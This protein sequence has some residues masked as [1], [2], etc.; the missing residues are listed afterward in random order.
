MLIK[1]DHLT[2]IRWGQ[3]DKLRVSLLYTNKK[4]LIWTSATVKL[5][6]FIFW[7][8]KTPMKWKCFYWQQ[9]LAKFPILINNHN[10]TLI[11]SKIMFKATKFSLWYF[12]I[13]STVAKG[14]KL[15]ILLENFPRSTWEFGKYSKLETFSQS[16]KTPLVTNLCS[17][18]QMLIQYLFFL[19]VL[20]E[21]CSTW[22]HT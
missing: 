2:I 4:I 9:T 10:F 16:T 7:M 21:H 18:R 6:M 20:P 19:I 1:N 22:K 5:Q 14:R 17:S 11:R 15:E 8:F 3:S 12:H 13:W